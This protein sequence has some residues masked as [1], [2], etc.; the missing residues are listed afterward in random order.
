MA[1][2][3]RPQVITAQIFIEPGA[4]SLERTRG[5]VIQAIKSSAR[6]IRDGTVVIV[7]YDENEKLIGM[8]MT[9][10][11]SPALQGSVDEMLEKFE[12]D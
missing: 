2:G 3:P 5:Y 6:N 7:L 11:P 4:E 10:N 9:G 12:G 8:D 1:Q